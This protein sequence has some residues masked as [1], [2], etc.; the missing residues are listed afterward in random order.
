MR[1]TKIVMMTKMAK[2]TVKKTTT[3]TMKKTVKEM[4]TKTV[5]K[6]KWQGSQARW[7][8]LLGTCVSQEGARLLAL[9]AA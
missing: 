6:E 2:K 5:K 4:K 9:A 7:L 8:I 3:K 1:T